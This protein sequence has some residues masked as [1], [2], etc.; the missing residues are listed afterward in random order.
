M[1]VDAADLERHPGRV[2]LGGADLGEGH[3]AQIQ[4]SPVT[5][6]R[7]VCIVHQREFLSV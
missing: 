5:A 6:S 2:V 1:T 4:A 7:T 3:A